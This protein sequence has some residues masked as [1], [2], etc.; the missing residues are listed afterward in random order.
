MTFILHTSGPVKIDTAVIGGIRNLGSTLGS[1]IK[2]EPSSGEIFAR[3]VAL[4]GQK[5]VVSFTAE[6]IQGVLTACGPKGVSLADKALTLYGSKIKAGGG[7]DTTGHVS[8][9]CALGLLYPKILSVAHQGDAQI[10][11]EAMLYNATD[12]ADPFTLTTAATLPTIANFKRWALGSC[13]MGGVSVTQQMNIN[14]DFGVRCFGEGA[15]SNIR[16]QIVAIQSIEPPITVSSSKN[17]KILDLL[18]ASGAFSIVLR[19]RLPGGSFGT[20]TITIAAT[21]GLAMQDT[22]FQAS[23]HRPG[24]I[25]ISG[26]IAW[27]GTND[28]LTFTYNAG[29]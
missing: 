10:S 20:A 3:L 19:D 13:T 9:A 7:I 25:S 28:P 12:S 24:E 1:Q 2:G 5:P 27:D 16:D 23:G 14:I 15:D 4:Y 18:G 26:H 22:P 29:T 21:S 6:D 17:G 11:Y 8:V